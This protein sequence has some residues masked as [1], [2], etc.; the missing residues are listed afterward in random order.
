M[1]SNFLESDFLSA[2]SIAIFSINR[3]Q[4]VPT[5]KHIKQWHQQYTNFK[6]LVDDVYC[7]SFANDP[8]FDFL[9]PKLSANIKFVQLSDDANL[10]AFR[11]LLGKKGHADFLKQYWQFACIV[12][13]NVVQYYIEQPFSHKLGVDTNEKIYSNVGPEKILEALQD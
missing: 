9:M 2:K 12:K 11:A 8:M 5:V 13:D 6:M 7:I 3:H 4:S 10:Q 1:Q